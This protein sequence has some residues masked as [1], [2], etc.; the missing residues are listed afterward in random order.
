MGRLLWVNDAGNVTIVKLMVYQDPVTGLCHIDEYCAMRLREE[1]L[2]V[3]N[4]RP[5]TKIVLSLERVT[6]ICAAGYRVLLDLRQA[7]HEAGGRLVLCNLSPDVREMF[8][9]LKF[10]EVFTIAFDEAQAIDA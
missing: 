8:D 10:S 9:L 2:R 7:V 3:V 4:E 5:Q 1:L 6:S